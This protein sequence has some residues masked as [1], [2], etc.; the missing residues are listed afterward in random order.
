[1]SD[2]LRIQVAV[3]ETEFGAN[4]FYA[5]LGDDNHDHEVFAID[6]IQEYGGNT[7]YSVNIAI[8]P[9]EYPNG[10]YPLTFYM[11]QAG[12]AAGDIVRLQ[13]PE[14]I[15]SVNNEV[16]DT[17]EPDYSIYLDS[18]TVGQIVPRNFLLNFHTGF[19]ASEIEI[20]LTSQDGLFSESDVINLPGTYWTWGAELPGVWPAGPS[21]LNIFATHASGTV[22]E[23]F[24]IN[25]ET[26]EQP[27]EINPADV[28]LNLL[29]GNAQVSGQT[30]L[31]AQANFSG[32]TVEFFA[33]DQLQEQV[34]QATAG[35]VNQ[36]Y[37]VALDTTDLP[38]GNYEIN[39]KTEIDDT[40]IYAPNAYTIQVF[41]GEAQDNENQIYFDILD[42]YRANETGR[43]INYHVFSGEDFGILVDF[44]YYDENHESI[45][46]SAD[47]APNN[48]TS[49]FSEDWEDVGKYNIDRNSYPEANYFG[50]LQ[51][52]LSSAN[53]NNFSD[54]KYYV[55]VSIFGGESNDLLAKDEVSFEVTNGLAGDY[56]QSES[57]NFSFYGLAGEK[58]GLFRVVSKTSS[59]D[60]D[61]YDL[62]LTNDETGEEITIFIP[63]SSAE[64][65]RRTGLEGFSNLPGV[66][67]YM[68]KDIDSTQIP[69][70][71]YSLRVPIYDHDFGEY[72]KL[73]INNTI[74]QDNSENRVNVNYSRGDV[75]IVLYTTCLDVGI[76]DPDA[77]SRF[78]ATLNSLD[79]SCIEEGIYEAAAC[80]DYLARTQV[81]AEC[82]AEGIVN[83]DECVNYLLEKYSSTVD[84]QLS[85]TSTCSQV[86]RDNF[87]N[88][89]VVA[90][91]K[92]DAIGEVVDPLF[93]QTVTAL[94]LN[95]RLLQKGVADRSMALAPT[96]DS[97]V[98][99]AK[100]T[101]ETVLEDEDR[102]TVLNQAVLILDSDGDGL[103]DD[104]EKY[105]GT[106]ADNKDTD[107]DGY[108][109]A[110]EIKNGYNPNGEG[111]LDKERTTIDKIILSDNVLEQPK[112]LSKKT[113]NNFSVRQV[114]ST[115]G[116][117]SLGGKA[118]ANS[119]V[120]IYLYSDLP[121]VMT[122]K[123]DNSGNW[124]YDIQDS[125][126]D[127][128]HQVYVTVNDDTGKIVKQSKPISF[129]VRS[130][131]AVSAEDYFDAAESSDS[132]RSMTIYYILGAVLLVFIAL[133]TIIFV[134]SR[135]NNNI[136][137][138]PGNGQI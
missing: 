41:N 115:E 21:N 40:V 39:A 107:G 122:T 50:K 55:E 121:L 72:A 70:G 101:K 117:L 17:E 92:Q 135:K 44:D 98:Y 86:L 93:G 29:P 95:Q 99:V 104:L 83:S 65:V 80:E 88:R 22:E 60:L 32:L 69:N 12:S 4:I 96:A 84:C 38:N 24:S 1:M 75:A 85:D 111:R 61:G 113:D 97:N 133:G 100:S 7:T 53:L 5:R 10:E 58:S 6:D 132:I 47:F 128:H 73:I 125:L 77:C 18:P 49:L 103:S 130:A 13:T 123:T 14:I 91:K 52:I 35:E 26:L 87:L 116:Q 129:L 19:V 90:R 33:L 62:V 76:S 136:N 105:Y 28:T 31:K 36:Q 11:S 37:V 2:N 30:N 109:D 57:H 15:I 120:L 82:Q 46:E 64:E 89:L 43:I 124:V 108:D 110:T 138:G 16:I 45:P 126:T 74:E 66:H 119:W 54:G 131:Q 112:V 106:R 59:F 56:T 51:V 102:L 67:V 114:E 79:D 78:R 27:V 94:D 71:T 34:W 8:N 68:K 48:F 134:H 42:S 23:N 20:T 25:I 127:G 9:D 118:D 3:A 63:R 81:E 137:I